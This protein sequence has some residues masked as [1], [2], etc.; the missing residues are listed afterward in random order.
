MRTCEQASPPGVGQSR[1]GIVRHRHNLHSVSGRFLP[2]TLCGVCHSLLPIGITLEPE[3]GE[4]LI[5]A[6]HHPGAIAVQD[7]V[8]GNVGSYNGRKFPVIAVGDQIL[9][10]CVILP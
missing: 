9:N 5:D 8:I 10:G 3:D 6:V 1:S 2:E 4:H 7:L